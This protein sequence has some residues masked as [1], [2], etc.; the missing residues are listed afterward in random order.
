M[1]RSVPVWT[2]S[3][4]ASG[5]SARRVLIDDGPPSHLFSIFPACDAHTYIHARAYAQRL[6]I[7]PLHGNSNK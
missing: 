7:L 4:L 5:P 6:L 2:A 3:V 1:A